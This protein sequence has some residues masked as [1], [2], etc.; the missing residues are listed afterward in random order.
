MPQYVHVAGQATVQIDSVA[1]TGD[2]SL[3]STMPTSSAGPCAPSGPTVDRRRSAASS[4]TRSGD[5][6]GDA[7]LGVFVRTDEAWAWLDEFL[8]VERLR[9][10]LPGDRPTSP[11]D[12]YRFPK[13]RSLNFVI[14]GLL[15]E[16]VAASTRQDAQ[17]K[18]LGEWLRARVVPIPAGLLAAERRQPRISSAK[19]GSAAAGPTDEELGDAGLAPAVEFAADLVGRADEGDVFHHRER[20]RRRGLG[21]LALQVQLLHLVGHVAVAHPGEHLVVEVGALRAH[22]A[23]VQ[24]EERAHHVGA[25]LDVVAGDIDD[26]GRDLEPVGL[27]GLAAAA[28][29]C[30]RQSR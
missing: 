7:N 29:P 25:A 9:E 8:T 18:A 27:A 1:P 28:K 4:G 21:L 11:I 19:V 22:A 17:A 5:K 3:P 20:D 23:G 26:G 14:H 12:R 15:E 10:L 2:R 24:G 13:I 30:R 16:G 6:G